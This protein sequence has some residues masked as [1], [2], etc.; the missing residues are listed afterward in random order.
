[1]SNFPGRK[2]IP[3]GKNFDW[4]MNPEGCMYNV[5]TQPLPSTQNLIPV[6]GYYD[7]KHAVYR[8]IPR[9]FS[10][11]DILLFH[12]DTSSSITFPYLEGIH[13]LIEQLPRGESISNECSERVVELSSFDSLKTDQFSNLRCWMTEYSEGNVLAID[14]KTVAIGIGRFI[15]HGSA[16]YVLLPTCST[17]SRYATL[18]RLIEEL[19]MISVLFE[20]KRAQAA[21]CAYEMATHFLEKGTEQYGSI[22]W[23]GIKIS[24]LGHLARRSAAPMAPP[25]LPHMMEAVAKQ[26]SKLEDIS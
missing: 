25:E 11:A 26:I 22:I 13:Q 19:L 17:A 7:G 18:C 4:Y 16:C 12:P 14:E 24:L 15:L 3:N 20:D 1:M 23:P 5:P 2:I 8:S 10:L 21:N 9:R 6:Q